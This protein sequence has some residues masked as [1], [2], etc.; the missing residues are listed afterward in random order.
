LKRER[1]EDFAKVMGGKGL[2]RGWLSYMNLKNI[3]RE[4]LK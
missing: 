1:L 2:K 4:N 3:L